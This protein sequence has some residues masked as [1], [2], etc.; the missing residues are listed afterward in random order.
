MATTRRPAPHVRLF[1]LESDFLSRTLQ[2]KLLVA[3]P[4]ADIVA[5][6]CAFG[7]LHEIS[8]VPVLFSDIPDAEFRNPREIIAIS[9]IGGTKS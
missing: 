3:A 4:Y 6:P 2:H 7:P 9:L 5:D 8:E 1:H